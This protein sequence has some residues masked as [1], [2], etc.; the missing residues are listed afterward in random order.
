LGSV[1]IRVEGALI[2]IA[3]GSITIEQTR[4][5]QAAAAAAASTTVREPLAAGVTP[6][7]EALAAALSGA[8]LASAV[9]AERVTPLSEGVGDSA[10]GSGGPPS[11]TDAPH[12]LLRPGRNGSAGV[13]GGV[14]PVSDHSGKGGSGGQQAPGKDGSGQTAWTDEEIKKL[15]ALWPTHSAGAIAVELGRGLNSVRAKIQHLGLKR[16]AP[17]TVTVKPKPVPRSLSAAVTADPAG[18][19][20][21]DWPGGAFPVPDD[22]SVPL[23]DHHSGQCRWIISAVWPVVYCGAPVVDSSSWCEQHARRVFTPGR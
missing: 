3:D 9:G 15:R 5:D 6:K 23:L 11:A 10:G 13:P 1:V 7:V 16:T 4:T 8:V 22:F 19:A 20:L 18:T 17:A 12:R 14:K 21:P 2:T